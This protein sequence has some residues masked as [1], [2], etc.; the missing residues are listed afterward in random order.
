MFVNA[1]PFHE[2]LRS[3]GGYRTVGYDGLDSKYAGDLV[4][5]LR[6]CEI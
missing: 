6:W 5:I 1:G 2:L 3:V 4:Q